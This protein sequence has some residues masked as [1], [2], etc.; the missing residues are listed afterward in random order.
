MLRILLFVTKPLFKFYFRIKPKGIF[1]IP[2]DSTVIFAPNHQSFLDGVVLMAILKRRMRKKTYVIA[3]DKNFKSR[4]RQSFARRANIILININRNLKETLQQMAT[5][6]KEGN[7][8]VIFPEGARSR[9]GALMAFKK[10]FA[11]ISKEMHIP[12]VPV[13]IDGSYKIISIGKKIPRP[14]KIKVNFLKAIYP[15]VLSYDQIVERTRSAISLELESSL[16]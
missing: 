9:D 8:I 16:K 7:N 11:I 5:I 15:D 10:T 13:M 1:N 4:F 3:K 14:G 2:K 12:V 6:V